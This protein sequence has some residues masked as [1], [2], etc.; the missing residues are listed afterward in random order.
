MKKLWMFLHKESFTIV[1][2]FGGVT[3]LL[4]R[5]FS[6]DLSA[7]G[8]AAATI[9]GLAFIHYREVHELQTGQT[10]GVPPAS[11]HLNDSH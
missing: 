10:D 7:L 8:V 4:S 9:S 2:I 5:A 11:P 6:T 1:L 3:T